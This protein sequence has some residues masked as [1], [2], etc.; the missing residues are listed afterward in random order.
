MSINITYDEAK[1][2]SNLRKHGIDFAVAA[3]VFAGFTITQ[4][5]TRAAYDEPRFV[6]LGL[7]QGVLVVVHT[8]RDNSDHIISIRKAE[9]HEQQIYWQYHP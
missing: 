6:T 9:R 1:R 2:L 4:E 8:P 7:A 5:D 3:E